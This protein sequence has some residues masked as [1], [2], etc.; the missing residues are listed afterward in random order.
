MKED[1]KEIRLSY[2]FRTYDVNKE[3]D[4]AKIEEDLNTLLNKYKTILDN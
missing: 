1:I 2:V 4:W 3:L